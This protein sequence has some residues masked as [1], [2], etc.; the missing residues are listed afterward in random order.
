MGTEWDQGQRLVW[1]RDSVGVRDENGDRLGMGRLGM[2][3]KIK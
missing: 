3:V 1:R 2:R